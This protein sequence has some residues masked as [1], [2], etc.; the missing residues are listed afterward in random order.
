MPLLYL[1]SS[2]LGGTT[3]QAVLQDTLFHPVYPKHIDNK[4]LY[5]TAQFT[6]NQSAPQYKYLRLKNFNA[7]Y[8]INTLCHNYNNN[9][10]VENITDG[11]INRYYFD[12]RLFQNITDLVAYLNTTPSAAEITYEYI[13]PTSTDS[14]LAGRVRIRYNDHTKKWRLYF[15]EQSIFRPLGFQ[16]GYTQ[17]VNPTGALNPSY[18]CG[19]YAAGI[20]TITTLLITFNLSQDNFSNTYS[21]YTFIV[22]AVLDPV[23]GVIFSFNENSYF[24]QQ[25]DLK[26]RQFNQII[27]TFH[28]EFNN[29][30]ELNSFYEFI[31]ELTDI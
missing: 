18:L 3:N 24:K 8:N 2:L 25:I 22:N 12:V 28:D 26:S 11:T 21:S 14:E 6:I 10:Q 13:D 15:D 4:Y 17:E 31:L 9:I 23:K 7:G 5:S 16:K 1:K 29:I 19:I 27:V 20:T 30:V